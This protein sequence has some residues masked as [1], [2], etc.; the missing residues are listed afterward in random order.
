MS[1]MRACKSAWKGYIWL[2]NLLLAITFRFNP[3]FRP[4]H[5]RARKSPMYL[6]SRT[7]MRCDVLV[8]R[9]INIFLLS[10]QKQLQQGA[11]SF[12]PG[13]ILPYSVGLLLDF[14]AVG[15]AMTKANG[16]CYCL[17]RQIWAGAGSGN[18]EITPYI[19]CLEATNKR[20]IIATTMF[21]RL[22]VW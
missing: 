9:Q 11:F 4:F 13:G 20:Y 16:W 17:R 7:C 10:S 21:G 1:Y 12:T 19:G 14:R 5:K 15:T 2:G 6:S 8:E 22:A 3:I 18:R